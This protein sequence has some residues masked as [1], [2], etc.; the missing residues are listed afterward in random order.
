MDSKRSNSYGHF[1]EV[2]DH[3]KKLKALE[4]RALKDSLKPTKA[5]LNNRAFKEDAK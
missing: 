2:E 3:N 4:Q 5:Q 1:K